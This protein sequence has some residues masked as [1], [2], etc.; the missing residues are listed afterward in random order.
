MLT[1]APAPGACETTAGDLALVGAPSVGRVLLTLATVF[2]LR[3]RTASMSYGAQCTAQSIH[4]EGVHGARVALPPPS[5]RGRVQSVRFR[6]EEFLLVGAHGTRVASPPLNPRGRVHSVSFRLQELLLV[7]D[8]GTRVASPT[9]NP[10]GRLH[11]SLKLHTDPLSLSMFSAEIAS[12]RI[13][14]VLPPLSLGF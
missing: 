13:P 9:L 12:L 8:H 10:R 5:S 14:S 11:R 3:V 1:A 4:D 7:G 6:L 2:A